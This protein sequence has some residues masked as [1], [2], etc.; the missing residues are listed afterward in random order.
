MYDIRVFKRYRITSTR[1]TKHVVRKSSVSRHCVS[2]ILY[3]PPFVVVIDIGVCKCLSINVDEKNDRGLARRKMRASTRPLKTVHVFRPLDRQV[4]NKKQSFYN[5]FSSTLLLVFKTTFFFFFHK[6]GLNIFTVY[7]FTARFANKVFELRYVFRFVLIRPQR[8][9]FSSTEVR[10][11]TGCTT[12][13]IVRYRLLEKK[14][15][16]SV[17]KIQKKKIN[18]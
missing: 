7:I 13:I 17:R 18:K 4:L 11:C 10:T 16:Q 15:N 5:R 6:Q 12:I 3:K 9:S 1:K 8:K 2:I 14:K